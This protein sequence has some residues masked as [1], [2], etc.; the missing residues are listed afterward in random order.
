MARAAAHFQMPPPPPLPPLRVMMARPAQVTQVTQVPITP[1]TNHC[2]TTQ[3]RPRVTRHTLCVRHRST[4]RPK[5]PPSPPPPWLGKLHSCIMGGKYARIPCHRRGYQPVNIRAYDTGYS[6][7][8]WGL[9]RGVLAKQPSVVVTGPKTHH[10]NPSFSLSL[11]LG[12]E[13]CTLKPNHLGYQKKTV[14]TPSVRWTRAFVGH[15]G[16]DQH[17]VGCPNRCEDRP[18]PWLSRGREG[19]NTQ[20]RN[21]LTGP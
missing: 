2:N 5:P 16:G 21:L 14:Q 6:T 20:R 11:F 10:N 1:Y 9:K 18:P 4:A 13:S 17:T 12:S 7:L 15:R 3:R 19:T 8:T